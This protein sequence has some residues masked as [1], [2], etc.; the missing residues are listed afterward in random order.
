MKIMSVEVINLTDAE[1]KKIVFTGTFESLKDYLMEIVNN[2]AEKEI[3][4]H[5][6]LMMSADYQVPKILEYLNLTAIKTLITFTPEQLYKP[7]PDQ[8]EM[9]LT[10]N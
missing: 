3:V 4:D 1:E 2:K 7:L 6:F 9:K 8:Y 5:P 10:G